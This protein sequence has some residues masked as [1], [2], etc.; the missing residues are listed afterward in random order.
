MP[1]QL[2][3]LCNKNPQRLLEKEKEHK[4]AKEHKGELTET[5]EHL[6]QL[7]L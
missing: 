7:M 1:V 6:G 5:K 4:K 2:H 3:S